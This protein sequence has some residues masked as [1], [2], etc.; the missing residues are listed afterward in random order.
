[1]ALVRKTVYARKYFRYRFP[2]CIVRLFSQS[3]LD[4]TG[5]YAQFVRGR[6]WVHRLERFLH[7]LAHVPETVERF[8]KQRNLGRREERFEF[9]VG[10][11]KAHGSSSLRAL[12]RKNAT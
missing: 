11:I 6:S 4:P 1:M 9:V 3:S 5:R 2:F 7:G 8:P 12:L 10:I